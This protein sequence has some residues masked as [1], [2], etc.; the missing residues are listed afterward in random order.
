MPRLELTRLPYP[1]LHAAPSPPTALLMQGVTTL[2]R[3]GLSTSAAFHTCNQAHRSLHTS[4][5][6]HQPL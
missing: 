2:V 5:S 1:D 3:R 6:T 4:S